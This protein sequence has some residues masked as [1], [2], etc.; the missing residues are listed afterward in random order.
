M[1][2]NQDVI[3]DTPPSVTPIKQY[4]DIIHTHAISGVTGLQAELDAKAA[5][6]HTHAISEV[7]GLQTELD[8]LD[9]RTTS[10]ESPSTL[11]THGIEDHN[12]TDTSFSPSAGVRTKVLN[13][14]LG[15]FTN[16]SYKVAG[17]D[18]IWDAT[19]S[20]FDFA[21][22]GLVLGDTVTIRLDFTLTTTS[23]NDGFKVELDLGAG[24]GLYT[25]TLSDQYYRFSGTNNFTVISEIYMGDANTLDNPATIYIT[26]DASGSTINYNGHYVKYSL[27]TPSAT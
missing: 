25:L 17:R 13:N 22:A 14:G 23:S 27:M 21:G 5:S 20:E 7:T 1:T 6:V 11:F 15:A 16:L 2:I 10:L 3:P 19:T 4:A 26:P 24:A 8:D 18:S 9:S 12:S